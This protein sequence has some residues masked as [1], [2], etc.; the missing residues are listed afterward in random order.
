YRGTRLS[1]AVE[2]AQSGRVAF[3]AT[4]R[5]F[6][7]AGVAESERERRAERQVNR[8]LRALLVAAAVLLVL[9]IGG[10]VLSLVARDSART[11]AS[12][13]DAQ[14][15]TSDAERVGALALSA[16][17]FDQALLFAA[18]GI[19]LQDQVETRGNLL[20]VLQRNPAAVRRLDVGSRPASAL[21][22]SPDGRLLAT[23]D[24]SGTIRFTDLPTWQPTGA[25]VE[26]PQPVTLQAMAF[27]PDGRTLAV[28]TGEGDRSELHVVDVATRR[29]RRLGSWRGF[30]TATHIPQMSLAFAPDGRRLAVARA[31]FSD[32]TLLPQAQRLLVLDARTG[33]I[34]WRRRYP[35]RRG[36]Q[37][38]HLVF[39]PRG[40]LITS[41][42]QG[43]TL[44][45]DARTGRVV[46]RYPIGG[47]PALSPDGR[48]LALGLVSP[49]TSSA[50]S[51]SVG[52]LDLR[53]GRRRVLAHDLDEEWIMS[54]TFLPDGR[55]VAGAAFDGTYVWDITSGAIVER[56]PDEQTEAASG[57][58]A[59]SRGLVLV[60]PGDGG[61][62]AWDTDGAQRVGRAFRWTLPQHVCRSNPCTVVDDRGALMA[63]SLGD[64]RVAVVDLNSKQRVAR[65]PARDGES[66]EALAFLPG[67][68]RL[69]TGGSAGTVTLWDV[70]AGEVAG[71]LRY[72]EPVVAT[73]V[74]PDGG[75]IAV[76]R[77]AEGARDSRVEVRDLRSGESR[78]TR[79]ISSGPGF[80]PG[81]AFSGDGRTLVASAC[82]GR[83]STLAG[84]D[85]RSGAPRFRR[86]VRAMTFAV[87][88]DARRLLVGTETGQLMELDARTGRARRPATKVAG[89]GVFQIAVSPDGR[90]AAVS[91]TNPGVTLWD[92]RSRR[93]LGAT[94]EPPADVIPN[95]AFEPNG[96]LLITE[97]GRAIEWPVDRATLQRAACRVAGR[98]LLREEWANVLPKRPYRPAWPA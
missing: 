28:G 11:A 71:R 85:A 12:A 31:T 64:G 61:V 96:R 39:T 50:R 44:V 56:F 94:F 36:E 88:P 13:A 86:A 66:A 95:V 58:I 33:R 70:R 67:G 73:A 14:A 43:D 5:A 45:W 79:T 63:T 60:T 30:V 51:A 84:W 59:V 20:A 80:S 34:A 92:L 69:A 41:A 53:T 21:A 48:M 7:D 18:A 10:A 98:D 82:C 25:V 52:V 29:A 77:G 62:S 74:S 3:N 1:A 37:E 97:N 2:L 87:A 65:L 8:R 75:L 81:L 32:I 46:R 22:A 40:A 76:L 90:L 26:L 23:A 4:E 91:P 78:Y 24:S 35:D 68:R 6:L 93:R 16:P 38:V 27:S 47:R 19:E 17:T 89:S 57:G 15:L 72:T 54:L 55:R 9:A 49:R 42:A 83:A